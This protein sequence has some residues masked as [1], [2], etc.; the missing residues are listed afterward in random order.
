MSAP[1]SIAETLARG[2]EPTAA[3]L[4]DVPLLELYEGRDLARNAGYFRRAQLLANTIRDREGT[5]PLSDR[6]G[7]A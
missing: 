5:P 1:Q 3:Y 7:A 6:G 4:D 2:P